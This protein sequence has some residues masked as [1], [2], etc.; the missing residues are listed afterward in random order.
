MFYQAECLETFK[1][2]IEGTLF[3][4][5]LCQKSFSN[6][7]NPFARIY[8]DITVLTK[9]YLL[10]NPYPLLNVKSFSNVVEDKG[11]RYNGGRLAA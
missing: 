4:Y 2:R 11:Q 6:H 10:V 5:P 8:L 3:M 1:K 9:Y 7:H